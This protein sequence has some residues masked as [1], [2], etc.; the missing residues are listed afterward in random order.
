M[1][2]E[3]KHSW[4]EG[5]AANVHVHVTNKTAQAT[6]A[7]R[8]AKFTVYVAYADTDEVWVETDLTAELTIPTGT[9]TLTNFYLDIG[10]IALTNYLVGAQI[11]CTVKRI[12]AT[13]GTEYADSTFITQ[14][15]MHL[16]EDTVGSKTEL[17]K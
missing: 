11:K 2:N 10:D 12:A 4:K 13:G 15:G 9:S 17:V 8:Y 7:N 5:T 3:I 1:A 6:G 16:E 14:V